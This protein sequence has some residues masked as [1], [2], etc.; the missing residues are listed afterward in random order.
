[1]NSRSEKAWAGMT[2]KA[3]L[4]LCLT[5]PRLCAQEAA[6]VVERPGG[7]AIGNRYVER[8]VSIPPGTG[9]NMPGVV[10]GT[11][12]AKPGFP[13]AVSKSPVTGSRAAAAG[14]WI[15]NKLSGTSYPVRDNIFELRV[16][17]SGL[18]PAPGMDQNGENGV[19]LTANDF[20]YEGFAA[21][22]TKGGGKELVLHYRYEWGPSSLSANVFYE[23]D[24]ARYSLRKWIE[25]SDSL[26]GGQFIDR[27][28]VESLRF[29]HPHFSGG[30]LGQPLFENDL[31]LGVEYPAVESEVQGDSVRIGYVCGRVITREPYRSHTSIIGCAAS[32]LRTRD[33]FMEYVD[34]IKVGGTR[35][36]LLYNSWYDLRNPAIAGDSL[37]V[38]NEGRVL[39]T[40]GAFRTNLTDKFGVGLDAIVLDDGWD[41]YDDVWRIDSTRFPRGF[42]PVA[43][44]ATGTGSVLGL[45]ASPFGGYSNRDRRVAWAKRNGYETTGD[46][47]CLAGSRYRE[48]FRSS[49]GGF[50]QSSGA[51]YFKWD[52][53]LLACNQPGHGHPPGLYSR[54]AQVDAYIDIMRSVRQKNPRVFL[55]ITTGAWLSPWWLQYADCMWM[56]GEDYAYEESAPSLNDRQKSITYKDVVLWDDLRK[57]DLQFP[58]SSLMTHGII[59]GRYN[60]LGGASESL[61]SFSDEVMMYFGRG[62]MMWE[63]YVSPDLL[64]PG[65]W[66]AIASC[67]RW[68]KANRD[69]LMHTSMVL[70][71]PHKCEPYGYLHM[72]RKKGLVLL[73]N[74]GPTPRDIRLRMSGELVDIDPSTEYYVNVIYPYSM[75]LPSPLKLNGVLSLRL[76]GYQVLAAE[77]IP[78]SDVDGSLPR[79]V[80]YSIENGVL[81]TYKRSGHSGITSH[82]NEEPSAHTYHLSI[83]V[84]GD[85]KDPKLAILLESASRLTREQ[86]PK[87]TVKVNNVTSG[88]AIEEGDGSW[89]WVTTGLPN[90]KSRVDFSIRLSE[91]AKGTVGFWLMAERGL[92]PHTVGKLPAKGENPLPAKPYS[93]SVEYVFVPLSHYSI[94]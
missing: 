54:G 12:E 51:G 22:D 1:M 17:L 63:L 75:L 43:K 47:L 9:L 49:M 60:L 53:I 11:A 35:P 92:S 67:A 78:A 40:I 16:V 87:F 56:Q 55:N 62:V 81:T 2:G 31:F 61:S 19:V 45:W 70:G 32:P 8:V 18:G 65:E 57:L 64:S 88:P 39:A 59:K 76:D 82:V 28:L 34:G 4:I 89:F 30:K 29:T 20:R 85:C 91:K 52:G 58:V 80:K 23:I 50:E 44:A 27:I 41:C 84:S 90:G 21:R 6:Y 86:S 72:T 77:L 37:G 69:V 83:D 36:Y 74:P 46:F 79:G 7:F 25:I 15:V 93:P 94:R 48:Y 42:A 33:A 24:S 38:L 73:R 10:S 26:N 71:D 14:P 68:A 66:N 13:G 3:L 5:A